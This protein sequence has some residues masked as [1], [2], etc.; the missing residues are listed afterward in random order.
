MQLPVP[1]IGHDP[2]STDGLINGTGNPGQAT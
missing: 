2:F 1:H